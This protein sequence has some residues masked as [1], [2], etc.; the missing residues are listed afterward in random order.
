MKIKIN[1][2]LKETDGTNLKYTDDPNKI[3]TLKDV[4]S[5]VLLNSVKDDDGK[6]KYLKYELAKK[7]LEA[8][9]V[10]DLKT[11]EIAQ[12]KELI[13]VFRAPWIVGQCWDMLEKGEN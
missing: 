9:D 10:I 6:K 7:I 1:Q 8:K 4:M 13:G 2:N 12:V 3:V 11:D 5:G